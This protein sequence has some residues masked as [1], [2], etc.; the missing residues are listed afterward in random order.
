M[1]INS[2]CI[3][4]AKAQLPDRKR[5]QNNSI[6]ISISISRALHWSPG[7]LCLDRVAGTGISASV[8][9]LLCLGT[10][11]WRQHQNKQSTGRDTNTQ[12]NWWVTLAQESDVLINC[13]CCWPHSPPPGHCVAAVIASAVATKCADQTP[14]ERRL[15]APFSFFFSFLLLIAISHL[16]ARLHLPAHSQSI[17]LSLLV[18]RVVQWV[19]VQVQILNTDSAMLAL[20]AT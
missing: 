3:T 20:S 17:N 16:F 10:F 15:S 18:Y 13:C 6:S 8:F 12:H 9:A 5:E 14:P 1:P 7:L 4:V 19:S 2:R 11:V